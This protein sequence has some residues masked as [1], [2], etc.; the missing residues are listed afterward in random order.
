MELFCRNASRHAWGNRHLFPQCIRRRVL[1][2]YCNN[3]FTALSPRGMLLWDVEAA[4]KADA[5]NTARLLRESLVHKTIRRY[6]NL[7]NAFKLDAPQRL[8]SHWTIVRAVFGCSLPGPPHYC[9]PPPLD[10][11]PRDPQHSSSGHAQ[12]VALHREGA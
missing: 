3:S 6:P 8:Q 10:W 9:S 4:P 12:N 1:L 7:F 5:F 2:Y 11:I